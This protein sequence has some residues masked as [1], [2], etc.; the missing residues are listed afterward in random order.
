MKGRQGSGRLPK[1]I[2]GSSTSLSSLAA[3]G[4]SQKFAVFWLLLGLWLVYLLCTTVASKH[5]GV[6]LGRNTNS[7]LAVATALTARIGELNLG[8]YGP[9]MVRLAFRKAVS[10]VEAASH[11]RGIR[12][13]DNAEFL[14]LFTKLQAL[15]S[16]MGSA[17][18]PDVTCS[19]D[20]TLHTSSHLGSDGSQ[21]YL[22]AADM[23]NNEELLPHFATQL[24]HFLALM[25]T[26][27]VFLS[28][29]ESG[30]TDS[31]GVTHT[32]PGPPH[33]CR[34]TCDDNAHMPR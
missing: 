32:F 3:P 30:S 5:G 19:W 11:S 15:V 23:H 22:I 14:D 27:S 2:R 16:K 12:R 4:S 7:S 26:G 25:P 8:Q 6:G 28:L 20:S 24:L 21:K 33:G 29:Y 34:L 31:T 13:E 18:P 9:D 17:T 10:P 1:G